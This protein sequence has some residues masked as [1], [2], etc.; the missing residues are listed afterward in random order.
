MLVLK[1]VVQFGDPVLVAK[2]QYITFLLEAGSLERAKEHLMNI[3]HTH[4]HTHIHT[5]TQLKN[6][7]LL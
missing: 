5:H 6:K 7:L 2:H 3:T 1:S 4:T